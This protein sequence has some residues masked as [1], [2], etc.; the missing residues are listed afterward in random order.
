[1]PKTS[2]PLTVGV[3]P[4]C[5]CRVLDKCQVV[6]LADPLHPCHIERLTEKVD[7]DHRLCLRR[8]PLFDLCG[9]NIECLFIHIAEDRGCAAHGYAACSGNKRECRHDHFVSVPDTRR[10]QGCMEC[11]RAIV[12]GNCMGRLAEISKRLFELSNLLTLRDH[13]GL[14]HFTDGS[15]LVITNDRS[16]DRN[17]HEF[18][19]WFKDSVH[20]RVH[21]WDNII[22]VSRTGSRKHPKDR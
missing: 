5:L 22:P 10:E 11:R 4:V 13:T 6:P 19:S 7:T 9:V 21:R 20:K 2:H 17:M 8:D 18:P 12:G 3:R 1:M 14:E 16:R 15:D